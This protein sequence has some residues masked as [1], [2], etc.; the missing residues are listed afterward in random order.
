MRSLIWTFTV[1]MCPKLRFRVARPIFAQIYIFGKYTQLEITSNAYW[2]DT[3]ICLVTK[4][5]Y[6]SQA[7]TFPTRSHL[8]PVKSQISLRIHA[9]DPKRL[10][11]DS[12]DSERTARMHR[13]VL[14][15][16]W[17][18]CNL[19]GNAVS[20]LISFLLHRLSG[21]M[22]YSSCYL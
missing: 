14:V 11:A 10:Q 8:R 6:V 16:A 15:F 19:V 1:R 18:T 21:S 12:E 17:R 4:I 9:K 7:T 3:M 5:R 2:Q 22:L 13:D 20:R